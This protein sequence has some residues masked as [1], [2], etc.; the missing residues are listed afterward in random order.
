[1]PVKFWRP[2]LARDPRVASTVRRVMLGNAQREYLPEP[3]SA[4]S[5]ASVRGAFLRFRPPPPGGFFRN[6]IQRLFACSR[7]TVSRLIVRN[8][9]LSKAREHRNR[10]VVSFNPYWLADGIARESRLVDIRVAVEIGLPLS[11]LPLARFGY[12][13][14]DGQL[15][16]LPQHQAEGVLVAYTT[17]ASTRQFATRPPN[18]PRLPPVSPFT[19]ASNVLIGF[20]AMSD[21]HLAP[22]KNAAW[23]A[24][25][26]VSEED[27][28]RFVLEARSVLSAAAASPKGQ[29]LLQMLVEEVQRQS[30]RAS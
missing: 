30:L 16:R 20:S 21:A 11:N 4:V 22:R 3:L 2:T 28:E 12:Q 6:D 13:A 10:R 27:V 29:I 14:E 24:A 15:T 8:E 25:A 5:G 23:A 26:A 1:M 18:A 9:T 17:W 19:I 7:A